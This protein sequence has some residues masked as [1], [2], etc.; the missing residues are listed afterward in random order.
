[1]NSLP[2][3]LYTRRRFVRDVARLGGSAFAAMTAL[4]LLAADQGRSWLPKDLPRITKPQK[5]VIL[6]AG[7]AGLATAYELGKLGYDCTLLE[8][9]ERPGGR[10]WT[11]RRGTK[12]TDLRGTTQ[13]CQFD[14][15]LYQNAGPARIPQQHY[16][17]LGYCKEFNVPIEVFSNTNDAAYVHND[18]LNLKLRMREARADFEG[19]TGELLAK[20]IAQDKLDLPLNLDE[21]EKLLELMR[22][23]YGL[24]AKNRYGPTTSRGYAPWPAGADQP[25][26]PTPPLDL[27]TTVD[28]ELARFFAHAKTITQQAAMFQPVGGMDALPYAMARHLGNAITYG[29]EVSAIRKTADGKAIIEYTRAGESHAV[30][31]DICVCTLAAPVAKDLG[32]DIAPAYKAALGRIQYSGSN[33]IG[34]QFKRRFW[35]EDDGIYGGISWTDQPIKQ[36]WYPNSGYFGKKG[37]VVGYFVGSTAANPTI[38]YPGDDATSAQI[39]AMSPAERLEFALA[40][41]EKIHPGNY[42]DN[43]ENSFSISWHAVRYNLGSGA[44]YAS[45]EQRREIY[46]VIGQPDGPIYFAGEHTTWSSGWM[47]GAFESALQTTKLIHQRSLA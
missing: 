26:A 22:A 24:D 17:T 41:G 21:R 7:V 19:H 23:A 10:A 28:S 4:D 33:K 44:R 37:V 1:M 45:P 12:E 30:T 3:S 42:R 18:R 31:A 6:G 11:I 15:G 8:A 36:I 13:V 40:A 34:L 29:A 9:R 47:A 35:E 14:E 20:A 27:K 39:T 5:V 43:Y 16:T 2:A 38:G 25:G 32:G 46:R